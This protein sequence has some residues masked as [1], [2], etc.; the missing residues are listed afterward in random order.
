MKHTRIHLQTIFNR[1]NQ[2]TV[3][4]LLYLCSEH[5]VP[6]LLDLLHLREVTL[7][8]GLHGYDLEGAGGRVLADHV[9]GNQ[10]DLEEI[11]R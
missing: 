9:L 5:E 8:R 3:R 6:T 11:K 2:K 10:G 4:I 1:S 7:D